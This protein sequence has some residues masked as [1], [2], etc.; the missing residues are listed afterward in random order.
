[1]SL[2]N[3]A[4]RRAKV[5]QEQTPASAN[6]ELRFRS[7]DASV[8]PPKRKTGWYI[9]GAIL[10]VAVAAFVVFR[11]SSGPSGLKPNTVQARESFPLGAPASRRPEAASVTAPSPATTPLVPELPTTVPNATPTVPAPGSIAIETNQP[12]VVAVAPEPPKP[13]EPKLQAIFFSP[14]NPSAMINGK[15]FYIGE[16]VGEYKLAAVDQATATLVGLGKTNVLA[17]P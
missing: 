16:K 2:I 11:F 14:P 5:A 17:L 13:A 8:L 9:V 1:M 12:P 3:D 4:L 7:V 10:L 15:T 6:T